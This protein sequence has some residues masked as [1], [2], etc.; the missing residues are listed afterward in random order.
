MPYTLDHIRLYSEDLTGECDRLTGALGFAVHATAGPPGDPETRSRALRAGRIRLVLTEVLAEDHPGYAYVQAHGSGVAD[1]ALATPDV[2]AAFADAVR[3]G[4]RPV[5]PPREND[6][7]MTAVIGG[8][9]DVVHTLVQRADGRPADRLP[10]F[11]PVARPAAPAGDAGLID[12]TVERYERTLGFATV[13][14]EKIE[15]GTQ[16]MNSTVVQSPDQTVTLTLIEPDTERDPG[17]IDEFLKNHGGAGVQ[18]LAF[19]TNDIVRVV[20]GMAARGVEFLRTPSAY[21]DLLA[22]RL[23]PRRHGVAVLRDHHILVDEDH[24]GQLYQIFARSTHPR[25]TL[26]FEAIERMGARTFGSRNIHA[27]YEAVERERLS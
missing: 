27:L 26:F 5:D 21:Y 2:P 11:A 22:R 23:T 6:G 8:F 14:T 25:G 10:G 15:V 24:D 19:S 17:Q 9:G 12:D 20:S 3:R 18:H 16:A 13:F 7:I 1:I 4:A